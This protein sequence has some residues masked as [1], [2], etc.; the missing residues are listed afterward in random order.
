MPAPPHLVPRPARL[1]PLPGHF[2]LDHGTTVRADPGAQ[3]ALDLLR[4]LLAPATGLPLTP[5]ETGDV[6]LAL[7]P[8]LVG[9]GGPGDEGYDLSVTP[10]RILLRA[11]R[12][13]GLLHGVQ[14]LR[15][16]LPV[17]ALLGTPQRRDTWP[18]PCAEITDGPRHPWRGAML[19]VARHFQPAAYLRRYVDL[20]AL[21]KLN[22][23][24]LHLTDDQGWRMPVPAYPRLIEIGSRR[25]RSMAGPA[26][27]TT[28]DPTPHE[29]S[30]S[31]AELT[32]LVA[33]AAERGVT[34]VPET[35]LP[36][37]TRAALAAYPELGNDPGARLGVWTDWGVCE[38]VLGVHDRA[39]AFCRDVLDEV[40]DVFPSRHV[41][42]GG[43]ECPTTE[44]ARTPTAYDRIRAEG[45][46]GPG[47]LRA[48]FLTRAGRHL[49][50]HGRTPT[51]WAETGAEL[52][53]WFTVMTWRD[54]A[55]ARTAARRGH[56][57]ITGDHRATYFDYAQSTEP[58]E[59]PAQPGAVVGL[60][61]VH[62]HDPAPPHW[63]PQER[64]RVIGAQGNVWTEFVTDP[65]HIE[66]LSFPR[67]CALAD[68]TWTGPS[69][70]GDDFLPRLRAHGARL[71]AL[72]VPH[73]PLDAEAPTEERTPTKEKTP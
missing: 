49:R 27:S 7:D 37:H 17:E 64:A 3:A 39:L 57:V 26:G 25:P 59:P 8:R 47:A 34:V 36:G 40:M 53:P 21:H 22:V 1:A 6:V 50:E 71:D 54:P 19:D 35:E 55:H 58:S 10:Y 18:L 4:T 63:D 20:L 52:P 2:T 60:R 28:Y 48:W 68:R 15:Q 67:L 38:N 5:A 46:D 70:W 72:G 13:A 41:H 65:S 24:H 43:D 73:R 51:A 42:I 29:G 69:D 9:A 45:L 12:P 62:G 44:W 56:A 16:L 23:L 31:R 32:G 66:Y 11:R 61:A 14:T 33:Y 30:Y